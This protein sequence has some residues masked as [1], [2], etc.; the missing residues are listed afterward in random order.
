[1]DSLPH[2]GDAGTRGSSELIFCVALASSGMVLEVGVHILAKSRG[3]SP[4]GL[5]RSP[6]VVPDWYSKGESL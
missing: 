3:T 2:R 4:V 6:T 5:P 1:M